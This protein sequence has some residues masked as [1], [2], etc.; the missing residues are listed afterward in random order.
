MR[1]KNHAFRPQLT[2]I[3]E[4]RAVPS[5]AGVTVPTGIPHI[6]VT[7]PQQVSLANPQVQAA[8]TAFDKSVFQ[9]IDV[10]LT[11]VGPNGLV[12]PSNNRAA[13]NAT[14]EASV[15]TL[16]EQL[17][18]SLNSTSTGS[19]NSAV[20]NQIVAAI[21]GGGANS[22]ESQ[23]LALS[24]E[25]IGVQVPNPSTSSTSSTQALV[26]NMVSTAEQVRPT[27]V[28]PVAEAVGTSTTTDRA[29]TANPLPPSTNAANDVRSAFGNFLNDYF[30]AVQG[31]LLAPGSNG[32]VNPQANRA[33]FN[34]K[35]NVAI[36]SLETTLSSSLSR[37]PAVSGLAPRIQSAIEGD[38]PGSLKGQLANL[39]TPQGAQATVVRDFTL[40]STQA[41]AQALSLISGDVT[42]LMRPAG[43]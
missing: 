9:A 42:K 21:V 31:T 35:V 23:L 43:P 3:L 17:V 1:K 12:V 14:I 37:Y 26:P 22:L 15:T 41:I 10:L 18:L 38:G 7:L 11:T 4:P 36:Q 6:S 27:T 40:Q 8:F 28:I 16:A 29:S 13:F 25:D 5:M 33:A 34:T 20:A 30:K 39:A 32:Q 2:E 24:L 19:T